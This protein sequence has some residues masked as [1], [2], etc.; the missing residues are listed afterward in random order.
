MYIEFCIGGYASF[1]WAVVL[2]NLKSKGTQE[3]I[4]F[5][6]VIFASR[7]FIERGY[8]H[9]SVFEVEKLVGEKNRS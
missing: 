2:H 8:N 4:E 5:V 3:T 1:L 7:R 9:V 6:V